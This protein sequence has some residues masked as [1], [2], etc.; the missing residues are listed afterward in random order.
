M[1]R[2]RCTYHPDRF[3]SCFIWGGMA[4][5]LRAVAQRLSTLNRVFYETD[6]IGADDL[7]NQ[8][9]DCPSGLRS[10]LVVNKICHK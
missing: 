1:F 6:G 5:E 8:G 7:D 3:K 4:R 2:M 10:C 9:S